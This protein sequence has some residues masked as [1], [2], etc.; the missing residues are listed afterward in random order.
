MKTSVITSSISRRESMLRLLD[1]LA[2]QT[3]LPDE[4]I[5]IEAGSVQWCREDAPSILRDRFI[6]LYAPGEA[7]AASRDRGR[8]AARSDVLFFLDDDIIM[9]VTYIEDAV[10]YL[11]AHDGVMG[12]G[13]SY[14][15][16]MMRGRSGVSILI[17]RLFG[18][19]ADGSCNRILKSGWADYVRAPFSSEVTHAQWLFGCN[20]AIRVKAMDDAKIELVTEMVAWSFLEDVFLGAHLTKA[21]G[22][23]LRVLPSL[24]VIHAPPSSGGRISKSTLRMRI[25]YRY[26]LWRDHLSGLCPRSLSHF[27]LGM[28]ANLLLML[29]QERALWVVAESMKTYA[30]MINAPRV[31][32]RQA[33]EFIVS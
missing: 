27:M 33:N 22:D 29:K 11:E 28:F 30:F 5:L 13:G 6:V 19:Y 24:E 25:L 18:I 14:V 20:A 8:R 7:L 15:D 1:N 3:F 12:V 10:S 26:I 17:G 21:Y 32:W 9:P 4:I 31:N 16:A 23:C 2:S